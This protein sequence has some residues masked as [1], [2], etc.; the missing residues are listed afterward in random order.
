[1]ENGNSISFEIKRVYFLYNIP[2][3]AS[4]GG[5]AHYNLH[6]YLIASHGS[7]DVILKDG[8]NIRKITLN[9]HKKA[10]HIVPG[11]WRELNNFSLS[12]ISLVLASEYY[13]EKDYIR[14]FEDFLKFKEIKN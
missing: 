13:D 10:L 7:F 14:N 4:R 8:I 3:G 2:E 9:N 5:H 11:L 12:S 1:M 6:Q